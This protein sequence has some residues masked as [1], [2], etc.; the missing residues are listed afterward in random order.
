MSPDR[1]RR[2]SRAWLVA[3]ADER[4]VPNAAHLKKDQLVSAILERQPNRSQAASSVPARETSTSPRKTSARAVPVPP[5]PASHI[6]ANGDTA[7]QDRVDVTAVDPHWLRVNWAITQR[8]LQRASVA[9]AA[10]WPTAH[11]VLILERATE[12]DVTRPAFERINV[13]P[14]QPGSSTWFVRVPAAQAT[15]RITIGFSSGDRFFPILH[16]P[17]TVPA[18]TWTTAAATV[19]HRSSGSWLSA[20]DQPEDAVATEFGMFPELRETNLSRP[21]PASSRASRPRW[22]KSASAG[23]AT[24]ASTTT[25][26]QVQAELLVRGRTNAGGTLYI[27]GKPVAI[28]ANGQFSTRIPLDPGR[29]VVPVSSTTPDR[30]VQET[31][32]YAV[33]LTCRNLEPRVFADEP[34]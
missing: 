15:Y 21:T 14:L 16:S 28:A 4:G 29:Q 6:R 33:D 19:H 34:Q 5:V 3:T 11:P 13:I 24:A 23:P 12:P 30:A 18:L 7:A 26:L 17:N 8:S 1:L 20:S 31:T 2:Q 25:D 10:A 27:A 32:V 22:S 9:L